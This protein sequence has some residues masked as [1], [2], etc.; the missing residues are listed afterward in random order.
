MRSTTFRIAYHRHE[1][2]STS[3]PLSSVDSGKSNGGAAH[4]LCS[5][6]TANADYRCG[7]HC[8][9]E[10]WQSIHVG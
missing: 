7:N 6:L 8:V 4:Y 2:Q 1:T 9:Q 5:L 10:A 3:I